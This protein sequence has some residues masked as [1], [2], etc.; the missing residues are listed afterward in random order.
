MREKSFIARE[1][2]NARKQKSRTYTTVRKSADA[3]VDLRVRCEAVV[4]ID[5]VSRDE[6]RQCRSFREAK[7]VEF[8]RF[9]L[10][11]ADDAVEKLDRALLVRDYH[12]RRQE[13]ILR[14][15][16]CAGQ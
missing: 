7:E 6:R 11:C 14:K 5:E 10:F 9:G 15:H 3:V 1:T 13:A 2:R 16:S 12:L 8:A 4:I